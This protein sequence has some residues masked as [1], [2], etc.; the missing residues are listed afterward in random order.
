MP[1][2]VDLVEGARDVEGAPVVGHAQGAAGAVE[3]RG[4]ALDELARAQGVGH[5]VRAGRLLLALG[6]AGGAGLG[7]LPGDVDHITDDDLIP[8]DPVDL[9][10]GKRVGGVGGGRARGRL[11]LSRGG[12]GRRGG[13]AE[14]GHGDEGEYS[15]RGQESAATMT[16]FHVLSMCSREVWERV[17][18][19]SMRHR[20]GRFI[21]LTDETHTIDG[22]QPCADPPPLTDLYY[23][24]G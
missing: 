10:R 1:L 18:G 3:G 12:G 6:G 22:G 16:Q 17:N 24:G 5:D 14:P 8:H 20:R 21:R 19:M 11:G 2:P 23:N 4:E 9:R 7:E 13:G 15:D